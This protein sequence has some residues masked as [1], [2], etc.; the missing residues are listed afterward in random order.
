MSMP[1]FSAEASLYRASGHY[2]TGRH[3]L[4]LSPQMISKMYPA[5]EVIEVFGSP[6]C[7]PGFINLGEGVCVRDPSLPAGG[8]LPGGSPDEPGAEPPPPP[9]GGPRGEPFDKS[10]T[11]R[12]AQDTGRAWREQCEKEDPDIVK[13]FKCCDRKSNECVKEAKKAPLKELACIH[14]VAWCEQPETGKG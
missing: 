13:V 9:G 1:R 5:M 7:R 11:K 8:G 10:E 2:R 6:P 3:A 14:A 12:R 4:N